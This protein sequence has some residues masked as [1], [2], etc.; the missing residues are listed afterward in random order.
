MRVWRRTGVLLA[1]LSTVLVTACDGGGGDTTTTSADGGA[2]TVA[3]TTAGGSPATSAP[4]TSAPATSAPA[5]SAPSTGGGSASDA[6][7]RVGAT[8]E[9]VSL[10]LTAESGAAIP[11][12]LLYNVYETLVKI[13]VDTAEIE[14]LLAESWEVSADGLTYTFNL[15][16]ATFHDGSP[17]VASD[18]KWSFERAKDPANNNPFAS[19]MEVVDTVEAPDDR[20]VVVT[21]SQPSSSWLFNMGSQVGVILKE[22]ASDLASTVNG[23][24][25]FTFSEWNRGSNIVLSRFDDYWG[26]PSQIG[27]VE[28]VYVTDPNQLNNQL[29]AD[30]LDLISNVQAPQLLEAFEADD[31]YVV[32]TGETNGEVVLSFNNAT[33]PFDDVRVRQAVRHA[34]DKEALVNTTWAGYGTLIGSMVPPGDPWYED[35]TGDIPYDPEAARALLAEAGYEDRLSITFDVPPPGYARQAAPFIAAQLNEV[36][37]Q[38]EQNNIEFPQWLDKVFTNK[39]FQMSIVAH[40]EPRDMGQ[41]GNPDYYWGYDNP[42]VQ[43]WLE[44]ADLATDEETRNELMAQVAAQ[45]SEDAVSDWL[46]LLPSLIVSKDDVTGFPTN[47]YAL[48]F[49]M[50]NVSVSE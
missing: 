39:N 11:Q 2:T 35:R 20:T 34:I 5:T 7:V 14:P 46:Y 15:V 16:E 47:A 13:N 30:Q 42:E 48:S 31:S 17:L 12:V 23:T 6:V 22:G 19:M 50:T 4:A 9:P 45:I 32:T 24:G 26:Q 8:L 28:F 25:P 38:V 36:G 29:L 27:G 41:Y 33:E 10:D 44:E 1:V 40:V 37:I 21:L 43:G 18:V 3:D 49:D